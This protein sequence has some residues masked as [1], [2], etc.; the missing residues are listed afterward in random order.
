MCFYYKLSKTAQELEHRFKATFEPKEQFE[1]CA[2]NGFQHP[3]TPVIT[4]T[5][6]DKIRLVQWGLIPFWAKDDSIKKNTLNARMETVAEKP[7]FRNA[8]KNRCLILADG[9]FEWQWLDSKGKLKQKYLL[10]LPNDEPFAFAGLWSEWTDNQ[11]GTIIKTYTIITTHANEM[12]AKI[13]NTKQRMPLILTTK[14]ELEW[15]AG[16]EPKMQ[17]ERLTAIKI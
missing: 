11:T 3:K 13:H 1:P 15:L 16:N 17:N 10:T 4:N 8:T 14:N 7:A 6:I 12:M 2:Y 5:E 9:F